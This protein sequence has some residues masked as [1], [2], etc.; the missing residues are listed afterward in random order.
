MPEADIG[1][2]N[3]CIYASAVASWSPVVVR[4]HN[5][6]PLSR[7][8]RP[9]AVRRLLAYPMP[10]VRMSGQ[11]MNTP[12]DRELCHFDWRRIRHPNGKKSHG[13]EQSPQSQPR[14]WIP[15]AEEICLS[16]R[17]NASITWSRSGLDTTF[18]T[19]SHGSPAPQPWTWPPARYWST[20]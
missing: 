14:P 8:S 4:D 12:R 6:T 17:C 11:T 13:T 7:S 2:A 15:H 1:R 9:S 5:A 16:N 19:I 18:I 3:R 20:R 10:T